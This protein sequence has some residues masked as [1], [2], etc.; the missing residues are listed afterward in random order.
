MNNKYDIKNFSDLID[1]FKVENEMKI[2]Q[3]NVRDN[4]KSSRFEIKQSIFDPI[5]EIDDLKKSCYEFTEYRP[6]RY[7]VLDLPDKDELA[8]LVKPPLRLSEYQ[9]K[10]EVIDFIVNKAF[11]PQYLTNEQLSVMIDLMAINEHRE[12]LLAKFADDYQ[13]LQLDPEYPHLINDKNKVVRLYSTCFENVSQ[14][15]NILLDCLGNDDKISKDDK[16]NQLT[17][18]VLWCKLHATQGMISQSALKVVAKNKIWKDKEMVSQ[19]LN[20]W[21]DAAIKRNEEAKTEEEEQK[22]TKALNNTIRHIMF[23]LEELQV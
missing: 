13:E 2:V 15:M 3:E 16:L 1:T 12:H 11:V 5:I 9:D 10:K 17:Q 4:I 18:T 19:M 6:K 8:L 7:P 23:D 22:R 20:N 21:Y 14:L